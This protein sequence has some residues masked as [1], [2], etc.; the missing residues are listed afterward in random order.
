[1]WSVCRSVCVRVCVCAR[2]LQF[3]TQK[4]KSLLLN[5]VKSKLGIIIIRCEKVGKKGKTSN[6]P[7]AGKTNI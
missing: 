2:V 3:K 4:W 6:A 1:M 5:S 7:R